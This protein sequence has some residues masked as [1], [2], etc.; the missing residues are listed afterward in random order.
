MS[1]TIVL[2]FRLTRMETLSSDT[3]LIKKRSTP[4]GI[5]EF[6]T[7]RCP[8]LALSV[9]DTA[10]PLKIR[11]ALL[12]ENLIRNQLIKIVGRICSVRKTIMMREPM[13]TVLTHSLIIL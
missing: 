2:W 5:Q 1:K 10:Q 8:G 7:I 4:V 12:K 11:F 9:I 6:S 13:G 3:V